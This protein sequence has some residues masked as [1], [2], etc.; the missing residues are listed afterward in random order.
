LQVA[1]SL[2]RRQPDWLLAGLLA[3]A[4]ASIAWSA[5]TGQPA[6]RF[7]IPYL[8]L[9]AIGVGLM[10]VQL[11]SYAAPIGIA[12]VAVLV[13]V[14]GEQF[15]IWSARPGPE[16]SHITIFAAMVLAGGIGIVLARRGDSPQALAL[17][18]VLALLG[19]SA[20][21]AHRSVGRWARDDEHGWQLV[22]A[23]SR[24]RHTG[25]PVVAAG[26]DLERKLALPVLVALR[27]ASG[28]SGPCAGRA[29]LVLGPGAP[30][31]ATTACRTNTVRTASKWIL[32]GEPIRLV[33][34]QAS[35]T[36]E[37][38]RLYARGLG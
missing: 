11:R 6:A 33:R 14:A 34:C 22:T 31:T 12:A 17:L 27:P 4:L 5:Q 35:R 15:R 37:A 19:G 9:T 7:Y 13:G 38:A 21:V 16:L 24:A 32:Q 2:V 25:C 28:R 36:R 26:L 8:T 1:V 20:W 3:T 10:L 23:V 18:A 29:F 30:R